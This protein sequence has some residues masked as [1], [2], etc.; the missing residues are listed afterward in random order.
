M[1]DRD[2]DVKELEGLVEDNRKAFDRARRLLSA[3]RQRGRDESDLKEPLTAEPI[4]K[5][6]DEPRAS[7]ADESPDLTCWLDLE[8]LAR[9]ELGANEVPT[10]FIT[11][12]FSHAAEKNWRPQKTGQQTIRLVFAVPQRIAKVRLVFVEE[13]LDRTQELV[14]RWRSQGATRFEEIVRQ[15]Y[16]FSP[17]GSTREVEDYGV[18]LRNLVAIELSIVPDISGKVA[19]AN[20]SRWELATAKEPAAVSGV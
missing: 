17:G 16:V 6:S 10:E 13:E 11:S 19:F 9:V 14:L 18:D 1:S 3:M 8:H 20:L 5:M 4:A 12:V 2:E 15:Q 7:N